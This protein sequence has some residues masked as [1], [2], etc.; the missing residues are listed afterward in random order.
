VPATSGHGVAIRVAAVFAL[1]G[2]A[3]ATALIAHAGLRPVIDAFVAAGFGILWAALF[4]FVPMIAN[5]RA[6]QILFPRRH[7][8]SLG[9]F[10][11]AVWLRQAINI[12]MPVARI[13]GELV[14]IRI[15]VRGGIPGPR[16]VASLLIEMTLSLGSQF[17]FTL[18]ALGLLL[19]RGA[20]TSDLVRILM[21]G[22]AV[23]AVLAI[24]FL[25]VQRRG[26][27]ALAG[28]LARRFFGERV[29]TLAGGAASL[30]RTLRALYRRRGPAV[31]CFAWLLLGWFSGATELAIVLYYLGRPFDYLDAVIIEAVIEA[32]GS[33][34]F[35]V[36][37]A[38]G[39][40]EG[41]FVAIGALLGLPPDI[42]LALALSRRARDALILLPALVVWQVSVGRSLLRRS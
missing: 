26:A 19:R 42:A 1:A 28:R 9:F 13:G 20:Y 38:L 3:G 2:L 12:L 37:G 16:A 36:P 30:D 18:V 29:A 15:L 31:R 10:V 39:V 4:H 34:A 8:R 6:W 41:G 14:S 23:G 11:W 25:L 32:V 7:R 21:I 22:L 35:F 33:A 5:G 27:F 17:L 24:G 40:Q